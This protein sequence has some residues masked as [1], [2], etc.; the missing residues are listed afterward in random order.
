V[1]STCNAASRRLI[2]T[3]SAKCRKTDQLKRDTE[4]KADRLSAVGTANQIT[5]ERNPR[6]RQIVMK[7]MIVI[8]DT[9][10]KHDRVSMYV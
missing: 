4:I 6:S 2:L 9:L 5:Y 8:L 3:S 7:C 10:N 1:T